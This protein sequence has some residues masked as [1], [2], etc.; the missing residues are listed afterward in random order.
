MDQGFWNFGNVKVLMDRVKITVVKR[1]NFNE[2][3]A[4][5][6]TECTP[7]MDPV[8]NRFNEGDVFITDLKAL[9][10]GFCPAAFADIF[11]Y[12][13]GLRSGLDY[14]WVKEKGKVLVCCT[15]GFRPVVFR[16]ERIK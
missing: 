12:V 13:T 16:L 3:H 14:S 5:S 11:R 2:I 7:N 1:L 10:E 15:D 4:D 8:C 9:P 6:N